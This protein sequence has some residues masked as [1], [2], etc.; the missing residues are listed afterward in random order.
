MKKVIL[1]TMHKN[2]GCDYLFYSYFDYLCK[3]KGVTKNKACQEMGVSRSVAAKWK[4][5]QTNP[6]MATLQ[7]ISDYFG[8]TL[9]ELLAQSE[10][11]EKPTV[12]NHE[13]AELTADEQQLLALYRSMN[14]SGRTA[15]LAA[16]NGFANSPA[17]TEDTSFVGVG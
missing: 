11:I 12:I 3:R 15:L 5:T 16:A 1:L 13:P 10:D 7:K 6:S 17:Y 2:R 8:V 4:S 9:D 14:A